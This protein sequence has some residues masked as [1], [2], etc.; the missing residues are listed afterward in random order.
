MITAHRSQN[1]KKKRVRRA[2]P[3]IVLED[4]LISMKS[5]SD[6]ACTAFLDLYR[7]LLDC[8]IHKVLSVAQRPLESTGDF[9]SITF[10]RFIRSLRSGKFEYQGPAQLWS[11]VTNIA[12]NQVRSARRNKRNSAIESGAAAVEAQNN[13]SVKSEL[14]ETNAHLHDMFEK[15]LMILKPVQR[16]AVVLRVV[17]QRDLSY[18]KTQLKKSSEGAARK[19]TERSIR[20]L[21]R[22]MNNQIGVGSNE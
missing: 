12:R 16:D 7:S 13:K 9:V 18:I 2:V 5:G 22:I 17:E 4:L 3:A 11:Y 19:F 20:E 15:A 1:I 14:N 10:D 21:V 8:Y 6:N